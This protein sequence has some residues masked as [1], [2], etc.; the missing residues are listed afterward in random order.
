MM[1]GAAGFEPAV[2]GLGGRCIIQA[3][4]HARSREHARLKKCAPKKHNRNLLLSDAIKRRKHTERTWRVTPQTSPIR[5]A[6]TLPLGRQPKPPSLEESESGI[7]NEFC[8]LEL[9]PLDGVDELGRQSQQQ[10]YSP[11]LYL[12]RG[13]VKDTS[14]WA[15][16]YSRFKP[17]YSSLLCWHRPSLRCL[18]GTG[19]S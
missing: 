3:M 15:S 14:W 11:P 6:K 4:L 2:P 9:P 12:P 1:A 17:F 18:L 13:G 19:F 10:Q 8:G 7:H 5:M 16:H